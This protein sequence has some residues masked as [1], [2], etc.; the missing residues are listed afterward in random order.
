MYYI[1]ILAVALSANLGVPEL[2]SSDTVLNGILF[3]ESSSLRWSLASL[4]LIYW[5]KGSKCSLLKMLVLN[6]FLIE[7]SVLPQNSLAIT[8]HLFP[9]IY[10]SLAIFRSSSM[11][12]PFLLMDGS[13]HLYQCC[14]HYFA[15]RPGRPI[16]TWFQLRIPNSCTRS[17]RIYSSSIVQ[18][19]FCEIWWLKLW[20]SIQRLWHLT[21]GL[22]SS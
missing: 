10:Y 14:L 4:F 13:K 19:P 12:H 2:L 21:S 16:A 11:V 5:L 20:S 22:L 9:W 18:V 1:E 6:L 15:M 7:W 3:T 8:A 17:V